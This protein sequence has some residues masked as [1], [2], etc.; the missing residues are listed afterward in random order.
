MSCTITKRVH[1]PGFHVQWRSL[2]RTE[3]PEKT[4]PAT[5]EAKA[6]VSKETTQLTTK[7]VALI[8]QDQPKIADDFNAINSPP[9]NQVSETEKKRLLPR[10]PSIAPPIAHFTPSST[11]Q[12]TTKK[13]TSASTPLFWRISPSTLKTMGKVFLFLGIFLL[14]GALTVSAGAFAANGSGNGAAW[15][16]FFFDLVAISQWFWLLAFIVLLVLVLYVSFLFVKY[17]MGGALIGLIVGTVLFGLGVFFL[18]LG[19]NREAEP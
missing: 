19:N 18:V 12:K 5:T 10:L 3:A 17:V 2:H 1:R 6:E 14:L 7:E 16:N 11:K 9:K 8:D 15:L 4:L 13:N